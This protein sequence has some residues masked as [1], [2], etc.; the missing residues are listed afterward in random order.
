MAKEVEGMLRGE[1]AATLRDEG[2]VTSVHHIRKLEDAGL[3][4]PQHQ[5]NNNYRRYSEADMNRLREILRFRLLGFSFARIA[6]FIE[7]KDSRKRVAITV[8]ARFRAK[9]VFGILGSIVKAP[10]VEEEAPS[11]LSLMEEGLRVAKERLKCAILDEPMKKPYWY[12]RVSAQGQA[13]M[14]RK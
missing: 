12:S 10:P 4:S 7:T 9:K 13:R 2:Y 14:R 3:V 8:E 11:I 6:E 1:A 5:L